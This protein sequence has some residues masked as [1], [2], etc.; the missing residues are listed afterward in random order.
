MYKIDLAIDHLQG[1]IC[2]KTKPNQT[3]IIYFQ[4]GIFI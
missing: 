2:P 4:K 1:L 3:T